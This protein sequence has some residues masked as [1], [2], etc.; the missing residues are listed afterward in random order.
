MYATTAVEALGDGVA[1][2]DTRGGVGVAGSGV[3]GGV[4]ALAV[5]A[6]EAAGGVPDALGSVEVA[7]GKALHALARRTAVA[8]TSDAFER[9]FRQTGM[10][11][12][13]RLPWDVARL[14]CRR[15]TVSRG[16]AQRHLLRD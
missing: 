4:A 14:L 1:D 15:P 7:P 10:E 3:D 2:G 13:M 8:R 12:M 9:W 5:A 6:G 11:A 16:V